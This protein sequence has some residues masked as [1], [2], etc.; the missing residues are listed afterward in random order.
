MRIG[1]WTSEAVMSLG[2]IVCVLVVVAGS[3]NAC[4]YEYAY[5]PCKENW[6]QLISSDD[7]WSAVDEERS[8]VEELETSCLV[9][10]AMRNPMVGHYM[11]MG[12]GHAVE[13]YCDRSNIYKELLGRED[14]GACMLDVYEKI[15]KS[16]LY[17]AG[18]CASSSKTAVAVGMLELMMSTDGVFEQYGSDA[19]LLVRE[20]CAESLRKHDEV[21]AVYLNKTAV[22]LM[23]RVLMAQIEGGEGLEGDAYQALRVLV[24]TCG[25]RGSDKANSAISKY[26]YP[27]EGGR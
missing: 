12:C 2:S 9:D 10:V 15:N 4:Q 18:D 27:A 20:I 22:V 26:V 1:R 19:L 7:M 24:E 17:D 5:H 25:E 23:S 21:G 16:A 6:S 14:A 3:G 13:Y 8:V 11:A